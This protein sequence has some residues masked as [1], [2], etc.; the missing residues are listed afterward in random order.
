VEEKK[1]ALLVDLFS[2]RIT[3]KKPATE[4]AID[5]ILKTLDEYPINIQIQM[6]EKSIAS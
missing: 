2:D 6:I 3:Q 4:K 5:L 1:K